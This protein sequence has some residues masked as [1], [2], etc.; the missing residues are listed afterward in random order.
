MF[1]TARG[2]NDGVSAGSVVVPS[3]AARKGR[4]S[5]RIRNERL[6]VRVGQFYERLETQ[7]KQFIRE[8]VMHNELPAELPV[9]TVANLLLATTEGRI[10]QFVRSGFTRRPTEMWD[11][12]WQL[13]SESLFDLAMA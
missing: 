12:Q 11:Q 13:L 5:P 1:P 10:S 7:L 2:K 4:T 8:G 9:N 3:Q 6:R